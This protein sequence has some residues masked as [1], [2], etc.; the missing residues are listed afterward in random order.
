MAAFLPWCSVDV[1]CRRTGL[2]APGSPDVLKELRQTYRSQ[3]EKF[4]SER[5]GREADLLEKFDGAPFK[6]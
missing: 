4:E 3:T 2:D 5:L 6:G 1:Q